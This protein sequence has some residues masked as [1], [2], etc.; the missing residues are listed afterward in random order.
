M[1]L[2]A[3]ATFL[4]AVFG[5]ML[6]WSTLANP[7]AIRRMLLFEDWYLYGLFPVAV[8]T[9]F[10]GLRILRASGMRAIFAGTPIAWSITR[11][12][13]RHLVGSALFGIGW[14]V[15]DACPGPI[16]AQVGRGLGWSLCTTL[17]VFLGLELFFRREET[18]A[19]RS[20]I[21]RLRV[22]LRGRRRS[23]V[24]PDVPA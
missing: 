4:G 18:L 6:C 21:D 16:A 14:A 17:G 22:P 12:E 5:F 7:D 24:V 1:R 3:T 9:G 20:R 15:A 11:P 10:V 23:A 2:K 8:A 19:A 13:R